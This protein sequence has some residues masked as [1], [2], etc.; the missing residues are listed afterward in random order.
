MVKMIKSY[1]EL[2]AVIKERGLYYVESLLN[3]PSVFE[4]L[5][6]LTYLEIDGY[7]IAEDVVYEVICKN[8][9]R[10]ESCEHYE[11]SKELH[12]READR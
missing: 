6:A 5:H 7:I 10:D 8:G 3:S 2:M 12:D 9:A 1:D 4:R 11:R